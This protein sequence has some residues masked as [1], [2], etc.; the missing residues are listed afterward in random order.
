MNEIRRI[1]VAIDFSTIGSQLVRYAV[2]LARKIDA[3]VHLVNVINQRD[4]EALRRVAEATSAFSLPEQIETLRADRLKGLK[5]LLANSDIPAE[6]LGLHVETG[7]P[8]E[9]LINAIQALEIDLLVMGTRGRGQF[10][11]MLFGST[12]ARMLSKCPVPLLT[13]REGD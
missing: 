5:M 11:G 7:V 1:M 13:L 6:G 8:Y 2:D 9:G 3:Q 4:I 12:A 10:S